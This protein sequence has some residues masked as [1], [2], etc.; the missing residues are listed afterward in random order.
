LIYTQAPLSFNFPSENIIRISS[1]KD[2]MDDLFSRKFITLFLEGGSNI[3]SSFLKE[4]YI[5]RV[6]LFMN[7]SFLGSGKNALSDIGLTQLS[8]RPLLTQ[9]ESRWIDGDILISGRI[10]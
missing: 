5:N 6:S 1:L 10:K 9:T 7:P 4:G 2:A 3:A 8:D